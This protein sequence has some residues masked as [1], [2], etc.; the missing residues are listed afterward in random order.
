[1]KPRTLAE[2]RGRVTCYE[3]A[4]WRRGQL[5][6]AVEYSTRRTREM[7]LHFARRHGAELLSYMTDEEADGPWMWDAATGRVTF[8]GGA[9]AIGFTGATEYQRACEALQGPAPAQSTL[10]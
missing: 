4:I 8:G 2:L 6:E 9:C 1:M 10:F 3:V 7:I 5:V